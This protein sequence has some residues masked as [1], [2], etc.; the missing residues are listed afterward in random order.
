VSG[1]FQFTGETEFTRI[2]VELEDQGPEEWPTI[3]V[4]VRPLDSDDEDLER[5]LVLSLDEARQVIAGL[6][7]VV[8]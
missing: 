7:A 1:V 3:G 4:T 2:E 6:A 8:R 5:S